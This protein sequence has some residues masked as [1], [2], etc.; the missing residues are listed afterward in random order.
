MGHVPSF[1]NC[2]QIMRKRLVTKPEIQEWMENAT[3]SFESQLRSAL[4]TIGIE[5]T[6]GRIQLSSIASFMPLD[7]S[8][9]WIP[10][11]SVL[12]QLVSKGEEGVD[13]L[14]ERA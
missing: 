6:T 5:T 10:S 12:T 2:K 4:A 9:K 14:I 1:K 8:R 3:A 11:H 13:I 7:D